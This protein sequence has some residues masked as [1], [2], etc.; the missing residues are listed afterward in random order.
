MPPQIDPITIIQIL[1]LPTIDGTQTAFAAYNIHISESTARK[2]REYA[3]DGRANLID[4]NTYTSIDK[5]EPQSC[6]PWIQ[7]LLKRPRQ[8]TKNE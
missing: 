2:W 3:N 1:Q 6:M 7:D 4:C 8:A 5:K